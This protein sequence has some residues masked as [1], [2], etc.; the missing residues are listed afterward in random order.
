MIFGCARSGTTALKEVVAG[1]K[2]IVPVPFEAN[3]LWHP[4]M[5]PWRDSDLQIPPIWADPYAFT[6]LSME[7]GREYRRRELTSIFGAYNSIHSGKR[8]LLKSAMVAFMLPEMLE[9]FPELKLIHLHRDGRAVAL[10]LA[11]KQWIEAN[12]HKELY[13]QKGYWMPFDD[14]LNRMAHHWVEHI[15]EIERQDK[16]LSLSTR[17]QMITVKYEDFCDNPSSLSEA[18]ADFCGIGITRFDKRRFEE[19]KQQNYKYQNELTDIQINRML[20]VMAPTLNKLGY[21]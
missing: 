18:I 11:K 13:K 8:L 16:M 1:H 14:L 3:D 4:S 10:S 15:E 20:D 21:D 6:A 7:K 12:K 19:V 9:L 5:Y 2:S 17:K